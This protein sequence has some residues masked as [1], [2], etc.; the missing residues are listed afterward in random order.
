MRKFTLLILLIAAGMFTMNTY[1]QHRTCAAHD[2]MLEQLE[3]SPKMK[4]HMDELESYT[5]DF[6]RNIGMLKAGET[7]TIPVHVIVVYS[8][9][10]ENISDAQVQSQIT[11]LNEDYGGSNS[12]LNNVP[13]E[14]TPVTSS[15]TGI[16]FVLDGIERH[17]DNTSSWGTN[18]AVKSA[19]PP[20]SPDTKL[21]MWICN[22][23]GGILGY[24]QFPGGDP[25]TDG[26]VFSPQYCGSSDYDDGSF[27]LDAPFDKGRTCTHEVGHYLNLRHIWGDGNCNADDYVDDTPIAGAANYG[28]PSYPD[29]SCSSNGGWTSDMFMNY[30]DYVDDQCMFMFSDGQSARMW[31]CLNSTRANLGY[32][33]GNVA[34]TADANGPYVADPGVSIS[35][36]SDGSNDA[37]GSIVSY[38]WDFGDGATSSQANPSHA[39]ANEGSYVVS[40][41]VTD[42]LGKTGSANTTATI[43]NPCTG[44]EACDGEI[45]FNLTTDRYAS[46][47]SWILKD[48]A[49]NTIESGSGYSNSTTYAINW[50][51]A[52]GS[53]VFTINDSYGDG[54]C[55][56]YGSGSYSLV[57]GCS[58]TMVSGGDFGSSAST[59]FCVPDGGTPP[60][61]VAPTANANGP[62]SAEEDVAV[63][64]S[65]AG[66]NDSDGTIASY[67]WNFG[68]G[69]TSSTANPSHTF[70]NAGTYTVTLTVTDNDGATDSDQATATITAAPVN[71][72]PTANA[73]GPYNGNEGVAINF[74]SAGSNDSD[75]TIAS[76]SW[77]FGD[78]GTSTAANPAHTYANAGT[79]TAT[80]TVID[81]DGAS[82]SDQASVT[83]EVVTGGGTVTLESTDFESGWGI[84]IDGG[85]DCAMYTSGSRAYSGSNAIDI[86]DNSGTGSST[87]TNENFDV[88]G[89]T[90]INVEFYFYAYSMDNSNEDFWVQFYDGSAW[91]TVATYAQSIDFDNNTFYV[92]NVTI[93]SSDYNFPSNAEFRFMCDASGNADDI[94]LDDITIVATDGSAKMASS[95]SITP[96]YTLRTGNSEYVVEDFVLYPN[97]ANSEIN[98]NLPIED[99]SVAYIYNITG[100]LIQKIDLRKDITNVN[101][102]DLAPGL[103]MVTVYNGDE[104]SSQKFLK[105]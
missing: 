63:S 58:S 46:E 47:T 42:D 10:Q 32:S 4:H 100:A 50:S 88:T 61:N 67:S 21:N 7:R 91:R 12:D 43:G 8:N 15:G 95:N 101:I 96:L 52:A 83:V 53:Y 30:M 59:E 89:F 92:A 38:L 69:G 23:G 104:V 24:A 66:S 94:Y 86:Q 34:P 65:S 72:A 41:T 76:Y 5:E 60:V 17:S 78:G 70:A 68:D 99:G 77:N 28:C 1:A 81:N 55:C 62:Y 40:L 22:I 37:D 102:N 26:V 19:Y 98:I 20:E 35:F 103:Y 11:V 16:Q 49:G 57:D 97:P 25:A 90:S 64:F 56:S 27:Y 79:Y 31:A 14:F 84:W 71:V 73:N 3:K 29:K 9:S 2:H 87:Y 82:D 13:S 18:D 75:G 54:I 85:R 51:L 6:V 80:L 93:S 44:V 36:S 74:S 45:T 105:K 33:D 39:Y 48:A